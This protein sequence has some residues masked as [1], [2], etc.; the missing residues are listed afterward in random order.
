MGRGPQRRLADQ[1][2]ALLRRAVP[3]LVPRRRATAT[4]TT[5][6]ASSPTNRLLPIDPDG[7]ARAGLRR[8]ATRSSRRFRRR[9]R[10][11]GHVGDVVAHAADRVRL[12]R[13][14]RSVRAHVP[15]G[16]APAGARHHPHVAVLDRRAVASRARHAA[17][18]ARRD[19]GLGAR[20]RPQ[21]DVEE[22]GQRR[23]PDGVDR[24]VRRRRAALLGRDRRAR[25]PT[26]RSTRTSSRSAASSRSRSSTCRSSCST[27]AGADADGSTPTQGRASRSTVDARRSST[28]VV[29][30]ATTAFEAFDYARALER[31]ETV[32]LGVLRRLRR[33]GEDARV[34]DGAATARA[35]ASA[36]SRCVA[37]VDAAAAVRAVPAVRDRRG[38]V[39]VARRLDPPRSVAR[40][41]RARRPRT[42]AT[43]SCTRSRPS[44]LGGA[45]G[46]R[47]SRSVSL[48]TELGHARTSY[49]TAEQLAA[50]EAARGDVVRRVARSR[51]SKLDDAARRRAPWSSRRTRAVRVSDDPGSGSTAHVNLEGGVGR[52]GA[53]R[54]RR[55]ADARAH[56]AAHDAARLAA[57]RVPDRPPH[58]HERQDVDR[59]MIARAARALGLDGR[60]YTS[61]NLERVNERLAVERRRRRRRRPRR[62][63]AHGRARR[64]VHDRAAELLR[65]PHRGRVRT[66]SRSWRSTSRWSRSGSAARGTRRTWST[67][68]SPSSPT[69]RSTT[70]SISAPT[71]ESI[72]REKAGIVKPMRSLVLGETDPDL[73]PIFAAREPAAA[74]CCAAA[75]SACTENARGRRA[76]R[77]SRHA[78]AAL[79][80]RVP[81]AARRAPGR[82]R[83]DRA[84][85]GRGVRRRAARRPRSC[86]DGVRVGALTRAAGVRRPPAARAARRREQ[87][88]RRAPRCATRSTRSSRPMPRTLVVGLLREKDPHEMLDRAR[89]RRH[90][91]GSC[92]AGRRRRA[93]S[94]PRSSRAAEESMGFE[95][96]AHRR[97]STT[98]ATRSAP[99]CSRRPTTAS[100]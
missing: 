11:D 17:V 62:A 42:P 79:R 28:S 56:P 41:R 19:L 72:A 77:R 47:A 37:L 27:S 16:P 33:A 1:P 75:T 73:V 50:L 86:A 61:P 68:T 82:Q 10:R 57:A 32:L 48:A 69:S 45:Q 54:A 12:G 24:E 71:R 83:R 93:R 40:P 13:R 51:S 100:S 35:S 3:G 80:R 25:A 21:E 70:S 98:C 88:R 26:P 96:D 2:A 7:R 22:E 43:R 66:G 55:G 63:A 44:A 84:R 29:R 15:D 31:T 60:P 94:I 91:S 87:R 90:R 67:P 78:A 20:P 52:P 34:P 95:P 89:A 97:A 8:G 53:R 92:A 23:H 49:D 39:V 5:T 14:P 74:R 64:T 58:R 65:D 18:D 38:V 59:R 36:A 30:E 46:R 81:P 6:T 85:R 76:R 4:P 99:R 9:S